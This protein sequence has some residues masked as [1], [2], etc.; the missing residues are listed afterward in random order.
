MADGCLLGEPLFS[1][2]PAFDHKTAGT[3]DSQLLSFGDNNDGMFLFEHKGKMIL[4]VNNEYA[5]NDLLHPLNASKKPETAEDVKKNKY[6]HGV[7]IVEIENKSG[8]WSIVKDSVY[9]RRITPDTNVEITG[10]ARG[11]MYV[12]TDQDLS[13]TKAKGTFNNCAS[14]KLLGELI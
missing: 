13:G 2:A 7:S 12:K 10:P 11:S 5:N 1:K 6:A 4:A 14:G 8:K 3:A 9:N